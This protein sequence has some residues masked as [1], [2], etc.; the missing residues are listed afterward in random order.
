MKLLFLNAIGAAPTSPIAYNILL[1]PALNRSVATRDADSA[2]ENLKKIRAKELESALKPEVKRAEKMINELEV[3][4]TVN[5]FLR[6][7]TRQL[8]SS[9]GSALRESNDQNQREFEFNCRQ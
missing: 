9:I 5:I 6:V 7:V 4:E 2:K 3:L 1:L 8:S